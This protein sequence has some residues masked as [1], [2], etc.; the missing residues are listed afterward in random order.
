MF[1]KLGL[2][3]LIATTLAVAPACGQD[4]TYV[5][6]APIVMPNR[7]QVVKGVRTAVVGII[8]DRGFG[9]G[10]FID[11]NGTVLT[12]KHVVFEPC[13]EL[14]EKTADGIEIQMLDLSGKD[15]EQKI[16]EN[17]KIATLG[18]DRVPYGVSYYTKNGDL[19]L[20]TPK[21]KYTPKNWMYL[22]ENEP[23]VSEHVFSI[24]HPDG[25]K[26]NYGE[27][28]FSFIDRNM[29]NVHLNQLEVNSSFGGS[30]APIIDKWGDLVG[31]VTGGKNN[32][33]SGYRYGYS[34]MLKDIR[35][36]IK[37]WMGNDNR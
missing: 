11:S 29:G 8:K 32:I 26:W 25:H 13:Q 14:I 19:A 10:T 23:V 6:V 34:H 28:Y 1:K 18:G 27:G 37:D 12:A 9:S 17:I 36:F 21:E 2:G 22:R 35:G 16:S 15:C 3:L 5:E 20:L 31:M 7:A 33:S 24:G 30:G 4:L